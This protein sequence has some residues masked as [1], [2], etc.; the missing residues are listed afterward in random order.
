MLSYL[1][2]Q[3]FHDPF[4]WLKEQLVPQ[5][6]TE[7]SRI[8]HKITY[9]PMENSTGLPKAIHIYFTPRV[10][11]APEENFYWYLKWLGTSMFV[12]FRYVEVYFWKNMSLE[13]IHFQ[14]LQKDLNEEMVPKR[15]VQYSVTSH[16]AYIQYSWPFYFK[17]FSS[18]TKMLHYV[19]MLGILMC[20][21][22][23]CDQRLTE[24]SR[25]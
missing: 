9:M 11:S 20:G 10:S 17:G 19:T 4:R 16:S 21:D 25:R 24:G 2:H 12:P 15:H 1:S 22:L 18:G 5:G 13:L 8:S 7:M 3:S 23:Q 14:Q 6:H